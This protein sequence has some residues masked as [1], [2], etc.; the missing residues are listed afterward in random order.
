M[1]EKENRMINSLSLKF[2]LSV[3]LVIRNGEAM[4]TDLD[5]PWRSQ[6]A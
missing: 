5:E 4:F 3:S 6:T 2:F 1:N